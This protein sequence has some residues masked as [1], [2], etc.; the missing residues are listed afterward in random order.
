MRISKLADPTPVA[1]GLL[2]G[3]LALFKENDG[4]PP[5]GEVIGRGAPDD[6][7]PNYDRIGFGLQD[8]SGTFPPLHKEERYLRRILPDRWLAQ[9]RWPWLQGPR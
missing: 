8:F 9:V 3:D 2:P 7:R 6:A 1:A 4:E 5:L